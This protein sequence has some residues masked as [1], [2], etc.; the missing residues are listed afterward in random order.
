[1]SNINVN[2]IQVN[3]NGGELLVSI[4]YSNES[5]GK[6]VEENLLL[7]EIKKKNEMVK[8]LRAFIRNNGGTKYFPLIST[9]DLSQFYG[10]A[11]VKTFSK[12]L[13]EFGI[14]EVTQ[15]KYYDITPEYNKYAIPMGNHTYKFK[16]SF[17]KILEDKLL[18]IGYL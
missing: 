1:M 3:D 15:N 11:D 4:K 2:G 6:E 18:A 8:A 16:S 7:E 12:Q 17:L 10:F 13:E 14:F 5:I 9:K